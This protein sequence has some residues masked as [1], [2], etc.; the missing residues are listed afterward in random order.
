MKDSIFNKDN[1]N[2]MQSLAFNEQLRTIE[3]ES[4]QA[5]AR[6]ERNPPLYSDFW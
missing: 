3:E 1:L 2:K 5:A 6:E 4:K